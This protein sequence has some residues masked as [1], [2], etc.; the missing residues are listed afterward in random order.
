MNLGHTIGHAVET[1]YLISSVTLLHGEAVAIGILCEAYISHQRQLL[2]AADF[3]EIEEVLTR[4]YQKLNGIEEFIEE[5]VSNCRQDKK[6]SE[7]KISCVLLERIGKADYGHHISE[8]E[9]RAAIRWYS[10]LDK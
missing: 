5:I 1:A 6:N 3:T 9:I 7:G 10:A 2:S 4:I 8:D